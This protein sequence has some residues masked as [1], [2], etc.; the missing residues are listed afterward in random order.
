M[1]NHRPTPCPARRTPA[2]Y[3]E[4]AMPDR[5]DKT[6][7]NTTDDAED[8]WPHTMRHYK[9]EKKTPEHDAPSPADDAPPNDPRQ[10]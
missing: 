1:P 4:S 5:P 7:L 2:I 6:P 10:A 9:W 8:K 3:T